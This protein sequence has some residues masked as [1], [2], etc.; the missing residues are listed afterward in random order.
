MNIDMQSYFNAL[1]A[2]DF[3]QQLTNQKL[4]IEQQKREALMPLSELSLGEG[5]KVLGEKAIEFAKSQGTQ[6]VKDAV[7]SKL[8]EAGVDEDT[9]NSTLEGDLTLDNLTSKVGSLISQAQT[10]AQGVVS[11]IQSQAE[12]IMS[13]IQSQAQGLK[14]TFTDSLDNLQSTVKSNIADAQGVMDDLSSQALQ[15][16]NTMRS[17]FVEPSLMETETG[18]SNLISKVSNFFQSP[19]VQPTDIEMVNFAEGAPEVS[20][21]A[22]EIGDV[23]SSGSKLLSGATDAVSGAVSGATEAVTGGLEGL[24]AGLD[25]T[26]ILAPLGALLSVG[27]GIFGIVESEKSPQEQGSILNPSSQFL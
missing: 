23:L 27:L 3:S 1:Q 15:E 22:P 24:S 5:V 21:I 14:Q 6:I 13:D 9:I 16:Y 10:K 17:N 7:R 11:D 20:S 4:Q 2:T 8:Q 12:G 25:T 18:T 26:G 19:Q